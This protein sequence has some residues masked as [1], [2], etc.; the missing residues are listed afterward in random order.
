MGRIADALKRAEQERHRALGVAAAVGEPPVRLGESPAQMTPSE[1][2]EKSDEPVALVDGLSESLVPFFDRSSLITEQY[3]SLRTRLL[4]QNPNYEHRVLAITSAVPKEGKSVTT[5]NLGSIL[6]EIRHL[7]VLVVDGDFRRSSLARMLNQTDG[8]GLAEVLRGEARYEEVVRPT[9]IPNLMFVS[10]GNTQGHSAAQLLTSATTKPV[11]R[12]MQSEYHY[13]IVDTPPATTVTDVGIIGQMCTGV[14]VVVRLHRTYEGA[15]RRAVRLL[16][17]NNIPILGCMIVGRDTPVGR[18][19]YGYGYGYGYRYYYNYYRY[20][21]R[22][23][24]DERK[25]ESRK[26]ERPVA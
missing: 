25:G 9:P 5:L 4:S 21:D 18:Y 11:F 22:S 7:R 19:G 15:A 8:P 10:A 13:T 24:G 26:K 14:I 17:V 20:S 3:R 23:K 2:G 6:A 12:R 16:Q 1:Q